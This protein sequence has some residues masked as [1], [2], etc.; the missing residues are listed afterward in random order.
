[1][2]SSK[3]EELFTSSTGIDNVETRSLDDVYDNQIELEKGKGVVNE[4]SVENETDTSSVFG[5]DR[6]RLKTSL[7]QRH[8][9]MLAVST[10][11]CPTH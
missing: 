10:K 11:Q 9:Q 6:Y 4:V 3:N 5:E 7:E 1:M 8:I 2:G